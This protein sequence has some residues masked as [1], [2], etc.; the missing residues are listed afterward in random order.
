MPCRTR[1]GDLCNAPAPAAPGVRRK[2]ARQAANHRRQDRR[3]A[4][5]RRDGAPDGL[6]RISTFGASRTVTV[7]EELPTVFVEASARLH[8]GVLDWGGSLGRWFGGIGAAAPEPTLLLSA[9]PDRGL[10]VEGEDADRA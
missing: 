4:R 9:R 6:H 3:A 7:P 2:R 1:D 10:N 8:F 5:I